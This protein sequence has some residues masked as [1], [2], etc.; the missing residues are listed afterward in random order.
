[1]KPKN[2]MLLWAVAS[3]ALSAAGGEFAAN[4]CRAVW[5]ERTLE[6]GN[7]RFSRRYVATAN[8]LKTV[9]FKAADGVE[10][11][12]ATAKGGGAELAVTCAS[13]RPSPV[14]E[15]CVTVRAVAGGVESV[16]RVFP[17]ASG[18][19]VSR[20][21]QPG[22]LSLD[23]APADYRALYAWRRRKSEELANAI[24]PLAVATSHPEVTLVELFDQTDVADEL[25]FSRTWLLS[26]C[27]RPW[28]VAGSVLDVRDRDTDEGIVFLRLSPLPASRPE[29]VCDFL[30]Q[31]GFVRRVAALAN[32]YP[33]AELAY[34]GGTPGR[35]R[36]LHRFQRCLRQYRPGRDGVFLSNTW[37]D[38]NRDSRINEEFLMRE[39]TAG[40]DL[41][42]DVI[43]IDDG[44]QKGRSSNSA[45]VK[46]GGGTWG[47]YWDVD[48]DFW[49]PCPERFPRGLKPVVS[50][51]RERGMRFGLWFGP[52][53]SNDFRHWEQDAACLL[54]YYRDLGVEYFKIDSVTI[55]S[56]VAFDRQEK[57]FARMLAESDGAMTFDLDCT[58]S[59]RPGYFGLAEIGPLFVENRYITAGDDR[60]WHPERTLRNLWTLAGVIDPVRLRMEVLNPLRHPELYGNDALAPKNWPS[61]APFAI[62]MCA[63]PLGWFEIS[64]LAAETVAAMKPLVAAWKR[65]RANVHGGV[66]HPVGSKPDG[67]SW[68]GFVT[69]AAD[70]TGGYA[71]L[72]RELSGEESYTLDLRPIFGAAKAAEAEVIG[73]RG[74]ARV[75][76]S[77]LTVS[78]RDPLDFIWVKF[79]TAP[80]LGRLG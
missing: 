22:D 68:T 42:V 55:R 24:D 71:L 61:D 64:G 44:W 76:G 39:V 56:G 38:G 52:D 26:T 30:I 16:L 62:A 53:S 41:G 48:P 4:G 60:L 67:F 69:E 66:T 51:A 25:S 32:G 65:E 3:C 54:G 5:T 34:R 74:E 80:P 79:K 63:S 35:T 23:G 47:R 73:G 1:M 15:P 21:R 28:A 9:S 14:S 8:G 12:R 27:E 29:K 31:G 78:V 33:V 77:R 45:S 40:A 37:G 19:L 13:E 6:V 46:K 75:D 20:L 49:K 11:V 17:G 7:G 59:T 43:Q 10:L 72:F 2:G 50:A 58:A 18:P 70:G 36:A 57:M